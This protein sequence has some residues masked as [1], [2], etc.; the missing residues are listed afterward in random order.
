MHGIGEIRHPVFAATQVIA[1][2][3]TSPTVTVPVVNTAARPTS[4]RSGRTWPNPPTSSVSR[5]RPAR[6][7]AGAIAAV[8]RCGSQRS[9]PDDLLVVRHDRGDRGFRAV[10]DHRLRGACPPARIRPHRR[11]RRRVSTDR[12]RPTRC[13]RRMAART[14]SR[15]EEDQ[16]RRWLER[17]WLRR[18]RIAHGGC[19][20]SARWSSRTAADVSGVDNVEPTSILTKCRI[21]APS[22]RSGGP[23]VI[24]STPSACGGSHR[25]SRCIRS[26]AIGATPY[27]V[28][29]AAPSFARMR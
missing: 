5:C 27:A 17:P 9:R 22:G 15:A 13:W 10:R 12:A 20:S 1:H 26:P 28:D 2:P 29:Q 18:R 8:R 16:L 6:M 25:A 11:V 21:A 3:G 4:T 24:P 23:T 14:T 19:R 7:L